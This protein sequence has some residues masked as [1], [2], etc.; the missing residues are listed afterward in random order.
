MVDLRIHDPSKHRL[1]DQQSIERLST[2]YKRNPL[3]VPVHFLH[4]GKTG[5]TAIAEALV[6]IA[7]QF[8]IVLH[9][10]ATRLSDIPSDHCVFFVVRHPIS[11]FISGFFSRLRCGAPRYNYPWNAAEA[12]AFG[13]FESPNDLAEALSSAKQDTRT[14][15]RE[16]MRG[17]QHVNSSY[18][19]WFAGEQEIEARLNS[20]VLVG[21]QEE[22]HSDFEILKRLLNLPSALFLPGDDV[23]A[24]RNPHHVNRRLTA[25]AER[26]LTEWYVEEIKFYEYCLQLRSKRLFMVQATEE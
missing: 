20:I 10:H 13:R 3:G 18:R 9:P 19:D 15:A 5:G 24:H 1:V 17:I 6:P 21:L 7:E 12:K 23:R 4:I 22:L 8:G 2:L 16:A 25:I 26:N 11:R 14:Q